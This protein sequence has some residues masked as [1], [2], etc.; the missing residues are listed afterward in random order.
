MTQSKLHGLGKADLKR[1]KLD[2]QQTPADI[3]THSWS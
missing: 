2:T 3:L 1:G